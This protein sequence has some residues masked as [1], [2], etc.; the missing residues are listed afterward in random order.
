MYLVYASYKHGRH[1][2]DA[3]SA[4]RIDGYKNFLRMR[5][6][7]DTLTIYP[8]GLNSVPTREE[9]RINERSRNN[10]QNEPKVVPAR[11]LDPILI[12]GPIVIDAANVTPVGG[13][14][15]TS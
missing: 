13:A 9:W 12:E 8:I 15:M 6:K 4:L 10:D 1:Y 14:S 2:N 11:G 3:F 5:L 7:G